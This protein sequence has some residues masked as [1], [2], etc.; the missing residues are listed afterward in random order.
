[1]CGKINDRRMNGAMK[2]SGK[3]WDEASGVLK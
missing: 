2:R 1:M 3:I